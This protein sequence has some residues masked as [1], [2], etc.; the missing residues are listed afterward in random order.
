MR[1]EGTV[2]R[3]PSEAQSLLIQ[4]TIGCPHNKCTF[5]PMYKGTKF[6]LR[7]VAEIIEDL[8][9]ARAYYGEYIYSLFFPDGNTI[10]MKTDQLLEI[11]SH[12]RSLFP[13]LQ[14]IT[15]YGSARYINKKSEKD[16]LRLK[17]AGL[18]RVHTGMESGDD[19]V[20]ARIQKGTSSEEIISAGKKLKEAGIETSEYYLTGI[21]GRDRTQEH[22]INSAR[23]LSAFSPDFIR[24]RTYVPIPGTPLYDDYKNGLF[25]LLTPHE[26][27]QEIRLLVENLVCENTMVL[28]DH[29]ANYW[30]ISGLLPRDREAMLESV[31]QALQID[32]SRFRPAHISHL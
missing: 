15:V 19:V 10:I 20:L 17:E 18:S 9:S 14:R 26:A 4:A 13:H 25:Q 2:Y 23:V 21:G 28:S 24:I 27:L 29:V 12:A 30:N 16:L 1:Y 8:N 11:F 7:D 31:D 32:E 6:R 5:C 3:P 22:A